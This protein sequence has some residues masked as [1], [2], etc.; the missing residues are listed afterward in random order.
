M[1]KQ[2]KKKKR[3]ASYIACLSS[4]MG[5]GL[6]TTGRLQTTARLQALQV[7]AQMSDNAYHSVH[8]EEAVTGFKVQVP[9]Y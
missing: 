3:Q 1:V 6:Q 7:T 4:A 5:R 2:I 8:M 9:V